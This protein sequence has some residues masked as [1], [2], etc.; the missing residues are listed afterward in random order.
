MRKRNKER[1]P[2]FK[3]LAL[4]FKY[5]IN[6]AQMRNPNDLCY[7]GRHACIVTKKE[8]LGRRPSTYALWLKAESSDYSGFIF[9]GDESD[10]AKVGKAFGQFSVVHIIK[11]YIQILP[12]SS[13]WRGNRRD[14]QGGE[15]VFL[16]S[17]FCSFPIV[18]HSDRYLSDAVSPSSKI[19]RIK[20]EGGQR[21]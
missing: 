16:D 18:L 17:C 10:R 7:L 20:P 14:C 2:R 6:Y 5:M 3:S 13:P 8:I 12:K 11:Q 4:S 9:V 19:H 21:F 15:K 1:L